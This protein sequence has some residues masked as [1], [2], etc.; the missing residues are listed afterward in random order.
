[1]KFSLITALALGTFAAFTS[2]ASAHGGVLDRSGCHF[3]TRTRV[4][5]CHQGP[6]KADNSVTNAPATKSRIGAKRK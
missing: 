6:H 2:G 5:H 1:M 4:Y 3:D